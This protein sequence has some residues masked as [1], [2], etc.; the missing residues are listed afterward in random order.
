MCAG[1][2]DDDARWL[3]QEF[4]VR[5]YGS[6][7]VD[8]WDIA[9][10]A[11]RARVELDPDAAVL[12]E[13][14]YRAYCEES[15]SLQREVQ[16]EADRYRQVALAQARTDLGRWER[17]TKKIGILQTAQRALANRAAA[18]Q[19]A[20]LPRARQEFW[21]AEFAHAQDECER[22]ARAQVEDLDRALAGAPR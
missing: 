22:G 14:Q 13:E 12:W 10:V 21:E 6:M 9:A 4:A 18:A 15:R 20:L 8:P 19:L 7:A 2:P 11:E 3:R 16:R 5:A 17:T 1:V